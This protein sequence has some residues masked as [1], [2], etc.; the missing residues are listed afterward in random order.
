MN[1]FHILPI[2]NDTL[3]GAENLTIIGYDEESANK[4][5]ADLRAFQS[6]KGL[7]FFKGNAECL[8]ERYD[9]VADPF[10][11]N[12]GVLEPAHLLESSVVIVGAGSIG[13]FIAL[14]LARA[15]VGKFLLV[16]DDILKVHNLSRHQCGMADIGK[17][18]VDAVAER[19]SEINPLAI[20]STE[21][22]ILEDVPEVNLD[23]HLLDRKGI[24][25]ACTDNREGALAANRLSQH[26]QVPLVAMGFWERAAAGEVFYSIPGQ[27]PCYR[28]MLRGDAAYNS[29]SYAS[30]RFYTDEEDLEKVSF[31]PG[32]SIDI[33]FVSA[34]GVKV[35][36]ALLSKID[37]DSPEKPSRRK[38][39]DTLSQYTLICN[40]ND[41]RIGGERVEIFERPLQITTSIRVDYDPGCSACGGQLRGGS[42][43]IY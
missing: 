43:A 6:S 9:L 27:T 16:D 41:P 40:D 39:L 36:L 32:I 30:R 23:L 28:C 26:Y 10:S 42:D 33:C 19:I 37:S 15:G 38:L 22:T 29:V 24:I 20:V 7:R 12:S 13:S 3:R 34:V 21:Q 4:G 8:V 11:R 14:E 2:E 17:Y 1:S 25:V 31:E 18:K 35:I 5:I